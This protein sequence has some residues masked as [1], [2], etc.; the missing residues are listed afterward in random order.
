MVSTYRWTVDRVQ[1][2]SQPRVVVQIAAH[3]AHQRQR[4][5]GP[6]IGD[7][8][9]ATTAQRHCR[10]TTAWHALSLGKECCSL[11]PGGPSIPIQTLAIEGRDCAWRSRRGYTPDRPGRPTGPLT[12]NLGRGSSKPGSDSDWSLPYRW[13]A[14]VS[15][16]R[17]CRPPKPL[18][19]R[20][21]N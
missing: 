19:N 21:R 4:I 17:R 8:P 6:R 10:G 20:V 12:A 15:A 18:E 13:L 1:A 16:S 2:R 5:S 14:H 7:Q 9:V 3:G 11:L